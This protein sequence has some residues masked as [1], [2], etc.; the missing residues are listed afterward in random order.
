MLQSR[1]AFLGLILTV[2][3]GLLVADGVIQLDPLMKNTASASS[4]NMK[5]QVATPEDQLFTVRVYYSMIEQY[6]DLSDEY[7]ILQSPATLRNLID[8]V[9]IRHPSMAQMVETMMIL[10]NGVPAKPSA[11]LKDGDE[12]QFIP[13]ATGG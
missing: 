5:G 11:A 1:R 9:V 2:G 12:V 3:A 13:L 7:F 4:T 10:L 6:T 8:T